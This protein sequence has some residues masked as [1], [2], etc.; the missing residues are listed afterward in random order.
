MGNCL[1]SLRGGPDNAKEDRKSNYDSHFKGQEEYQ[2][3]GGTG[4]G[5]IID[6]EIISQNK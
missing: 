2:E 1:T 4:V 6:K 3:H 5:D